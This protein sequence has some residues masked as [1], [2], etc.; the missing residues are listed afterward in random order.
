MAFLR[1]GA[2]CHKDLQQERRPDEDPP[3]FTF[4][5]DKHRYEQLS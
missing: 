4:L 1:Q 3:V 5:H 2:G